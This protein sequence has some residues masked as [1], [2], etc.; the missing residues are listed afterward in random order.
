MRRNYEPKPKFIERLNLLLKNKEDVDNF[1]ETAK[2]A[3]KK[4]IRVNTLKISPEELVKRLKAKNWKITQLKDYPEIIQI[5]SILK[6]GELGTTKEHLLGYYYVQEITSMMPILALK[7]KSDDI[8]LDLCAAPGSKTTQTAALMENKGTIIAN[9]V[10]IGRIKILSAN[11]ERCGITNTLVTRH[12]ANELCEKLEKIN[13]KF[14]K[15]LIDAPCSAEG[16]I[17]CSPRTLLEWSEPLL[18]SLSKKQKKIA[19][20]AIGLLKEDGEIIYSTCT[21]SPEEN[22]IIVQYLINNFNLKIIPI[23]LPIKTRPGLTKWKNQEFHPDMKHAVR[24][25]HHDNDME[26][27]FLCKLKK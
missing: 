18:K 1:L 2:T 14:D 4:S 9:D 25:Y 6:P 10:S 3:P 15:I 23:K 22:E 16:N 24:I 19:S 7:P 27:F 26:G 20:S 13:M 5:Q 8:L 17:R 11:L 21:H 12:P